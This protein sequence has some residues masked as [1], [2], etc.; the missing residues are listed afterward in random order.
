MASESV[1]E[2][3]RLKSGYRGN[4]AASIMA[5]QRQQQITARISGG[6]MAYQAYR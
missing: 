3:Q 5:Y 6:G 2:K 1:A 4:A